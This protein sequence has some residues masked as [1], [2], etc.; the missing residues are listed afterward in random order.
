MS[1]TTGKNRDAVRILRRCAEAVA[2]DGRVLVEER[3]RD[4]SDD[5][6][7]SGHDLL[8]LV[9]TGGH[10]RTVEEFAD[11]AHRA[12]LRLTRTQPSSGPWQLEMRPAT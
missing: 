9:L 11:L 1:S 6:D 2:P 7:T 12:G 3:V 10:E 8:M 5:G 4:G